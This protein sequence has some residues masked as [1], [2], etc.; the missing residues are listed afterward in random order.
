M[1]ELLKLIPKDSF[2]FTDAIKSNF[3][4]AEVI[5]PTTEEDVKNAARA[6]TGWTI[7]DDNVASIPFGKTP[8]LFRYVPEDHDEDE[9]TFMGHTGNFNGEDIIDIIVQQ[10]ATARFL[11]RHLYNFC[12]LQ[13]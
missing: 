9:K 8:W 7:D 10:P 11:S 3:P 13:S 4:G 1:K 5:E 6:F 2:V 12:D